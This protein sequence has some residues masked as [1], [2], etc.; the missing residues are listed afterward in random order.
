MNEYTYHPFEI[1]FCGLSNSGKTTLVSK[2]IKELST[3]YNVGYLKHDAHGFEMDKTGKDT[4]HATNSGASVVVINDETKHNTLKK[5]NHKDIFSDETYMDCDFV[6]LEGYKTSAIAKIVFVDPAGEIFTK[7]ES[8]ESVVALI[9]EDDERRKLIPDTLSKLPI[10]TRD[11]VTLIKEQLLNI[12]LEKSNNMPIYGL[13]LAGGKSSRMKQDKPAMVYHGEKT[14]LEYL[15]DVLSSSC[16]SVFI[17]CRQEQ[18][19]QRPYSNFNI[20]EDQFLDMGPMGGILSA[21][22]QHPHAKWMVLA[23]DLPLV[24][25]ETINQIIDNAHPFKMATA[26]EN[27]EG[28]R[29][30]PLCTLYSPWSYKRMLQL[31]G[32]DRF[33]PQKFLWN[34][35]IKKIP[36]H[37]NT[38]LS[39]ANTPQDFIEIIQIIGELHGN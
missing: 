28:R 29:L 14:Q 24:T 19:N 8:D 32:Q 22:R 9:V 11:D 17:S 6:I 21:M 4:W 25:Q 12:F 2:L 1:A 39:N 7:L 30:E 10:Y 16:E 37:E 3:D 31:V 20:V 38:N 13:V 35:P 15:Y 27:I 36:L 23:C 34:A 26:F 5:Y 18:K 33:C